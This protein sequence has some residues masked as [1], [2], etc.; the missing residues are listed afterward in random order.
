MTRS[1]KVFVQQST[2]KG[3]GLG[4]FAAVDFE[5]FEMVTKYGGKIISANEV[6]SSLSQYIIEDDHGIHWDAEHET[7]PNCMARF[8]NDIYGPQRNCHGKKQPN[9]AIF[10]HDLKKKPCYVKSIK[11]IKKGEEL[12]VDYGDDFWRDHQITNPQNRM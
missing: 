8:I 12:F 10:S 6:A 7:N 4:L 3:A 5:P 9:C 2:I 11:K 1:P